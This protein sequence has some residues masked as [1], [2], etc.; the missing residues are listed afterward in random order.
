[1]RAP[2]H[3][4]KIAD[5]YSLVGF[6]GSLQ[7]F[8]ERI[9]GRPDDTVIR[10][11]GQNGGGLAKVASVN[12]YV[13]RSLVLKD[14]FTFYVDDGTD[15]LIVDVGNGKASTTLATRDQH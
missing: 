11:H 8:A 15:V 3:F 7:E 2:A 13:Q 5:V 12:Y 14:S 4:T 6:E 9:Q 10:I 1:M